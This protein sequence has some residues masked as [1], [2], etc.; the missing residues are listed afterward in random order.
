MPPLT[1]PPLPPLPRAHLPQ[2]EGLPALPGRELKARRLPDHRPVAHGPQPGGAVVVI[3]GL[4]SRRVAFPSV[5]QKRSVRQSHPGACYA[6]AL[7]G[8]AVDFPSSY[9]DFSLPEAFHYSPE[10]VFTVAKGFTKW[11]RLRHDYPLF[12]FC[13]YLYPDFEGWASKPADG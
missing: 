5:G 9:A 1:G 10:R 2:V 3:A 13:V 12:E 6:H 11:V 8:V 4:L 7:A